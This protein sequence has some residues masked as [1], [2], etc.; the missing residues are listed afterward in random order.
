MME[1][2]SI[3]PLAAVTYPESEFTSFRVP[4]FAHSFPVSGEFRKRPS[5]VPS[6]PPMGKVVNGQPVYDGTEVTNSGPF[7]NSPDVGLPT[8][9]YSLKFLVRGT[10]TYVCLF[11]DDFGMTGTVIV[12]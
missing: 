12:K 11:H 8:N 3:F 7:G 5:S 1:K 4:V 2:A 9:S 10:F 6:T